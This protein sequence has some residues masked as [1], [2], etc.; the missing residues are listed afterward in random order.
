MEELL[1]DVEGELAEVEKGVEKA[2]MA[3]YM[4]LGGIFFLQVI[5]AF[6]ST[7][8]WIRLVI[9]ARVF[10]YRCHTVIQP[11]K[12]FLT[13]QNVEFSTGKSQNS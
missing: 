4:V 5:M 3:L 2:N 7:C 8:W 10:R 12:V 9:K 1:E 6:G 13:M 11:C